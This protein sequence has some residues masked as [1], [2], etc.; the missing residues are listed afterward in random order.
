MGIM[1]RLDATTH[2]AALSVL[3]SCCQ[4]ANALSERII[5]FVAVLLVG[6][7]HACQSWSSALHRGESKRVTDICCAACKNQRL[8]CSAVSKEY[9]T[10]GETAQCAK[11]AKVD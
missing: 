8:A 9:E 3:E 2:R 5:S 6:W 4:E 10:M 1:R 7:P 11:R